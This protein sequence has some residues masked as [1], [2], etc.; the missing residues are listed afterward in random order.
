[1]LALDTA[2]PG[3]HAEPGDLHTSVLGER[4]L[5]PREVL[6]ALSQQRLRSGEELLSFLDTFPTACAALFHWSVGDCRRAAQKLGS[7][8]NPGGAGTSIRR[9][10]P[11]MGAMDPDLLP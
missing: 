4:L 9:P 7:Q 8:I 2:P 3:V 10:E 11:A 5:V 6:T 1:M